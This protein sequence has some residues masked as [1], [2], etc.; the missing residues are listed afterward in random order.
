M[1]R[2]MSEWPM[3]EVPMEIWR[4]EGARRADIFQI[5]TKR[6]LNEWTDKARAWAQT[7]PQDHQGRVISDETYPAFKPPTW[8]EIV[9]RGWNNS[10]ALAA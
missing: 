7:Q 9:K 10:V 3:V 8:A 4:R 1:A 6:A 2:S 5:A